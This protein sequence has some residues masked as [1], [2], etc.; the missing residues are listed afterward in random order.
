MLLAA[1]LLPVLAGQPDAVAYIDCSRTTGRVDPRFFGLFSEHLGDSL[2][3]RLAAQKVKGRGFESGDAD[4]DGVGD[5]W[6]PVGSADFALDSTESF[7]RFEDGRSSTSQRFALD[8]GPAGIVQDRLAVDKGDP[9][10]VSFYVGVVGAIDKITVAL[11]RRA[12]DRG[13]E[14]EVA[15]WAV[16]VQSDITD[17]AYDWA[18]RTATLTPPRSA[19]PCALLILAE[20]RGTVWLDQVSAIPESSYRGWRADVV[21]LYEW[22]HPGTL[23]Y[24]GGNFS[25]T[26]HFSDGL[27]CPDLR[28]VVP[29]P[30]WRSYPEPNNI[31]TDEFLALC[32][33][34]GI[35]PVIC[36]NIGDTGGHNTLPDNS[37][38]RAL[39]ESLEWLEY[40]NS[41]ATTEWG[42]RRAA[43]GHP[44]PYGVRLWEIGNEI[45]YAH[46]H[47]QL[48]AAAYA[49][50]CSTFATALRAEDHDVELIG[51][52]HDPAWNRLLVERAGDL[53]DFVSLHIY[54]NVP[55]PEDCVAH[56]AVAV[57][58][59][60]DSH[61][62]AVS[63]GGATSD[64]LRFALN[65]WSYS[66]Q[67]WQGID[68]AVAS[69]GLL[70]ECLKR[71]DWVAMTNSS[72]SFVRF[73]NNEAIAFPDPEC[74]A[75]ALLAHHTGRDLLHCATA[76]PTFEAATRGD[77]LPA[78]DAV[79]TRDGDRVFVSLIN[80]AWDP[81][82]AG[83]VLDN[84]AAK[85][86]A[87]GAWGIR[88]RSPG[89][90]MSFEDPRAVEIREVDAPSVVAWTG[91]AAQ[92]TC[93]LPPMTV[94]VFE[95]HA[96]A[97][98]AAERAESTVQVR[99]T[100]EQGRP[101]TDA[102]VQA[103]PAND[104]PPALA[105]TDAQGRA[106]LGVP[107]G[108]YNLAATASGLRPAHSRLVAG[109][110]TAKAALALGSP[111]ASVGYDVRDEFQEP[112]LNS[113]VWTATS[114]EGPA[115]TCAVWEGAA[116]VASSGP[117]RFGLLSRPLDCADDEALVIEAT[118][119]YFDGLNVL[120]HLT[121][122][123]REGQFADFLELGIERGRVQVWG[124]GWDRTGP[125]MA[126]PAVLR[127]VI[128][129]ATPSGRS[130]EMT[131][132]GVTAQ[133]ATDVRW[134]L[135]ARPRVFLYGWGAGQRLWESFTV[136][137]VQV[138][139]TS[140]LAD[141]FSGP[142]LDPRLWAATAMV[143]T[144]G[145]LELS[146][147]RLTIRGAPESRFGVLTEPFAQSGLDALVVTARL[148][149]YEGTN[150]LMTLIGE[151]PGDFT[152]Y[153]EVGLEHGRAQGWVDRWSRAGAEV[154]APVELRLVAGP[155]DASGH[156]RVRAYVNNALVASAPRLPGQSRPLRLFLYGWAESRTVWD[157]VRVDRVDLGALQRESPAPAGIVG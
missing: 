114:L 147:G 117:S 65:E 10:E 140:V 67:Y 58:A 86:V 22:L 122:E 128:G 16:M 70:H 119:R 45:G 12:P 64:K 38:D 154:Q 40:C 139:R 20:G 155:A 18:K 123:G 151:G 46:I 150:G 95:F 30:A 59:W 63:A 84:I 49:E 135:G 85:P 35:E 144:D 121:T 90:L 61:I 106:A 125:R 134:L 156:R 83:F 17:L 2:D 56:S 31:G 29:S 157:W 9:T 103:V 108:A 149:E 14:N 138:P 47:G 76:G 24:P 88:E 87:T 98:P 11:A 112:D 93:D 96:P 80:R 26:Y 6:R 133:R 132:N 28:P 92:V 111:P 141:D 136:R 32:E 39:R 21:R 100:D 124:R 113:S 15:G 53:L 62:A 129:P 120:M 66:W 105:T 118:V 55:S 48:D 43:N 79:A 37:T 91:S 101:V 146:D 99:V 3:W 126:A 8:G 77:G 78:F 7:P 57:P 68:R 71:A 73:R 74:L 145:S 60:L 97:Q 153:F 137:R 142:S 115:G 148:A 94:T 41:A 131:V 82:R 1:S 25:Q 42:A 54:D 127:M 4:G 89:A 69:A 51:C 130:V 102:T 116:A 5:P 34:V 143:G 104:D 23:R 72:D 52:G 36:L 19:Y 50:R 13:P 81:M 109:P 33:R 27:G 110:G 152:G 107:S 75:I 44:A